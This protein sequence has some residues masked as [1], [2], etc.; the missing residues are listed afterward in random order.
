MDI[1]GATLTV[2]QNRLECGAANTN[3]SSRYWNP[4]QYPHHNRH[5]KRPRGAGEN[6]EMNLR[7]LRDRIVVRP[8]ER[9]KSDVVHVIMD[10]LPNTGEVL[11]VGPGEIDKKG[12]LIP[13]PIEIGQRIRFGTAEEY[14]AY[15]R[16]EYEGEELIVM[17]WKDVCFIEEG[18]GKSH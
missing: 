16:V 15:P 17:S 13:N 7:P 8:I 12:R 9:V 1:A 6:R 3:W 14:L 4:S 2:F 11:A 5:Q 10:E 18:D